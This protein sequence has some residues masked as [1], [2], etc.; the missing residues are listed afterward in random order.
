MAMTGPQKTDAYQFFVI[1]FNA[2]PGVEYMNQLNDAYAAGM[3]TQEI[4]NV[5]TTKPQFEAIYPRFYT[6]EQFADKLIETV[7]G[8]SASADTKAEAKADVQAALNTG[9]TKG[10]VIYQI[11]SNLAAKDPSDPEWGNT[12]VMLAN[13]VTVAQHFTEVGLLNSEDLAELSAPIAGVSADP[14]SVGAAIRGS[15]GNFMLTEGRDI[16]TGTS[17]DDVFYGDASQVTGSGHVTN[18]LGTGDVLDGGDGYDTLIASVFAENNNGILEGIYPR[19]TN[20]EEVHVEALEGNGWWSDAL[21]NWNMVLVDAGRMQ[22]VEQFWTDNSSADLFLNDVRVGDGRIT[23]DITF[24]MRDVDTGADLY[25]AFETNSILNAGTSRV[26]SQVLVRVA[27]VTTATPATPLANVDLTIGFSLDGN[28]VVLEHVRSTDGTYAGLKT[29]I[30]NALADKGMGNLIVSFGA[31]YNSVTVLSNTVNLPFT[32]QEIL[33]TDPAGKEFSDVTFDYS[34]IESVNQEFLV[35]GNAAAVEPGTVSSLIET[36]LILDN[37]GRG[38]MAGHVHIGGMSNSGKV[39]EKLNI[40]VDRSSKIYDVYTGYG[41]SPNEGGIDGHTRVSFKQIEVTSGDRN[42]DLTIHNVRDVQNFD[43]T[44]FAGQNLTIGAD[45][46]STTAHVFNTANDANSNDTLTINVQNNAAAHKNFSLSVNTGGG[47]DSVW[48]DLGLADPY[49]HLVG[50]HN[51]LINQK[52]LANAVINAGDGDNV[53]R[54]WG[55]GDVIITTGSG[56]DT[57]YTDN[58]GV[59]TGPMLNLIENPNFDPA[60]YDPAVPGTWEYI[61]SPGNDAPPVGHNGYAAFVFN[62]VDGNRGLTNIL[63][64]SDNGNSS[65]ANQVAQTY[66]AFKLTVQVTFKGLESKFIKV[67]YNGYQTTT[68][69]INQAVIE[70]VNTDA[71]LSKLITASVDRGEALVV[72]SLIDGRMDLADLGINLIAPVVVP[73]GE[74]ATAKAIREALGQQALTGADL[75]GS[76]QTEGDIAGVTNNDAQALYNTEFATDISGHQPDTYTQVLD[77]NAIAASLYVFDPAKSANTIKIGG[78]EVAISATDNTEALVAQAIHAEF[79]AG[80]K[81]NIPGWGTFTATSSVAGDK[82]TF[83]LTDGSPVPFGE[84]PGEL[85]VSLL[86]GSQP[87]YLSTHDKEVGFTSS[88]AFTGGHGEHTPQ[89][90]TFD[91]AN[92]KMSPT[93]GTNLTFEFNNPTETGFTHVPVTVTI[94]Q[95]AGPIQIANLVADAF[96]AQTGAGVSTVATVNGTKVTIEFGYNEDLGDN[97]NPAATDGGYGPVTV[98]VGTPAN[99]ISG[100]FPGAGS[101][102]ASF[103]SAN[104]VPLGGS[105]HQSINFAGWEVT[106]G[107]AIEVLGQQIMLTAGMNDSAVAAAVQAALAAPGL[108]LDPLPVNS[109]TVSY[110]LDPTYA[111]TVYASGDQDVVQAG[112]P[113]PVAATN[114]V[115]TLDLSG[116]SLDPTDVLDIIID[117]TTFTHTSAGAGEDGSDIFAAMGATETFGAVTYNVT[118]D[119]LT[120]ILT[121]ESSVAGVAGNP[122]S[123]TATVTTTDNSASAALPAAEGSNT[124]TLGSDAYTI[125]PAAMVTDRVGEFDVDEYDAT[126]SQIDLTGVNSTAESDNW[127]LSGA[128]EHDVVVLSTGEFSNEVIELQGTFGRNTIVNFDHTAPER[129]NGGDYLDFTAYMANGAITATTGNAGGNQV[130]TISFE[131]LQGGDPADLSVNAQMGNVSAADLAGALAGNYTFTGQNVFLIE[132]DNA[133]DAFDNAGEYLVV[134][135]NGTSVQIVGTLDFGESIT[136]NDA[137]LIQA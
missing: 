18:V 74:T 34:S 64:N 127:V 133:T 84:V 93:G 12:A 9:W 113:V 62:A 134:A 89:V 109:T 76:G 104:N 122:V 102:T 126:L 20:I 58:S 24:G 67:D 129:I 99:V 120:E 107:G 94:P 87:A 44:A 114:A 49:H 130:S 110:T 56:N 4:V 46:K 41:L 95:G 71:E 26:N 79:S 43:A 25:A 68:A 98:V 85:P 7:V 121:L 61:V 2:I 22:G 80:K 1:A 52:Q 135:T 97:S 50:Q 108:T 16:L 73:A 55:A 112:T 21:L 128:G 83:M 47:N 3:T 13:K 19:T 82:V 42:G 37:A 100:S 91:F 118:Y 23:K 63:G 6:D 132:N 111:G 65:L 101:L 30:E 88:G 38:S 11:F 136:L 10:D 53:V 124:G 72:R 123:S 31:A 92:I 117:G 119:A 59:Q 51:P 28:P 105:V 60:L 66:N 81:V 106:Q 116:L 40:E 131:S 36:N 75:A 54:T 48:L 33:I 57:I 78:V 77:V 90:T 69:Q 96:E 125:P 27:D 17:N 45:L 115:F 35:A 86:R 39:I 14:A 29:A 32:A 5:Y 103:S 8:A 137:N 15:A 70:A